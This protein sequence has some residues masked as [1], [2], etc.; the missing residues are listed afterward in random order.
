MLPKRTG[1]FLPNLPT[2]DEEMLCYMLSLIFFA[3]FVKVHP[4]Q[5][6][7]PCRWAETSVLEKTCT[8]EPP[9]RREDRFHAGDSY[10]PFWEEKL[11]L[12]KNKACC[13]PP[14][15]NHLGFRSCIRAKNAY[16]S[17][18][19]QGAR[20]LLRIERLFYPKTTCRPPFLIIFSNEVLSPLPLDQLLDSMEYRG[21]SSPGTAKRSRGRVDF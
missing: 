10:G 3:S 4:N 13:L 9:R 14:W 5:K 12:F 16:H 7:H 11:E 19:L 1:L 2:V 8:S 18:G 6:H 20:L 17:P 21:Y 15:T